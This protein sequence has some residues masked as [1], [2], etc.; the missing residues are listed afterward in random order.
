MKTGKFLRW[1]DRVSDLI[2]NKISKIEYY[3]KRIQEEYD[4]TPENLENCTKQDSIIYNL[5]RVVEAS[6]DIAMHII[7]SKKLGLPQNSMDA[8]SILKNEEI[9]SPEIF[10]KMK[11]MLDLINS[12]VYAPHEID[13]ELLKNNLENHL[14]DLLEYTNTI[15]MY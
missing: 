1:A 12:A 15:L 8:Y 14:S 13:L 6:N 7:A 10:Q 2:K 3:I 5:Q 4:N 11:T 9:L